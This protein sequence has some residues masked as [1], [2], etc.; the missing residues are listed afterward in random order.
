MAKNYG[1]GPDPN[2]EEIISI[3]LASV[4]Y[5]L[6]YVRALRC[7]VAGISEIHSRGGR[8]LGYQVCHGS[9]AICFLIRSQ[10]PRGQSKSQVQGLGFQFD[11][12]SQQNRKLLTAEKPRMR[13]H[14]I[15]YFKQTKSKT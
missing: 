4:Q 13:D 10:E 6:N 11:F 12:E 1:F 14:W 8:W 9:K 15:Y 5:I 7:I 2:W 3:R